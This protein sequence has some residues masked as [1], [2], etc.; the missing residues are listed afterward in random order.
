MEVEMQARMSSRFAPIAVSLLPAVALTLGACVGDGQVA[1]D[2]GVD[3]GQDS[4]VRQPECTTAEDCNDEDPCTAD[5]C[6]AQLG[7]MHELVDGDDD[8]FAEGDCGGGASRG[9]DCNDGNAT[10]YPGA[11]ELCDEL[12]NDCDDIVDDETVEVSCT[13][14]ADEDGFGSPDDTVRACNCP[15]GYIPPRSDAKF[16]CEDEHAGIN[17]G[18]TEWQESG[19]CLV[20]LCDFSQLGYDWDCSGDEEMRYPTSS[21]GSCRFE[22]GG[23][24]VCRGSGWELNVA[25]CGDSGPYR[26]CNAADACSQTL[27]QSRKQACR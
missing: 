20:E 24:A 25:N 26:Q 18:V 5:R 19:Y 1:P 27:I 22:G 9:G 3:A 10:V 7:C 21:D 14:D 12:D 17:P 23:L 15:D 2:G 11:P 16:D 4:G 13:R 8:G 6:S